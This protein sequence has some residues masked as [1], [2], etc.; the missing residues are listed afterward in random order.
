MPSLPNGFLRSHDAIDT[1]V[2]VCGRSK[3]SVPLN[4]IFSICDSSIIAS[5]KPGNGVRAV[6]IVSFIYK[7]STILI[8]NMVLYKQ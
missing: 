6:L 8:I 5:M 3:L 2:P 4:V 1:N 7:D